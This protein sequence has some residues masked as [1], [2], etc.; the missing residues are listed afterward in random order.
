MNKGIRTHMHTYAVPDKSEERAHQTQSQTSKSLMYQFGN[1]SVTGALW[2]G[3]TDAFY[4]A[5]L[6]RPHL[7]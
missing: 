7:L 2:L 5:R 1:K 4:C 3:Q 6:T